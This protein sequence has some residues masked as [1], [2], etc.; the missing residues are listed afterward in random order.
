VPVVT[1]IE[2]LTGPARL[3]STAPLSTQ[4]HLKTHLIVGASKFAASLSTTNRNFLDRVRVKDSAALESGFQQGADS[5]G[6]SKAELK[7]VRSVRSAR[8]AEN[9]GFSDRIYVHDASG[10]QA[11]GSSRLVTYTSARSPK[12]A[13]RGA[14]G[15]GSVI[16]GFTMG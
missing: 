3:A 6:I 1:Q 4:R 15:V 5:L 16:C 7:E 11:N 9:D 10:K 12:L 14:P 13:S 2:T 8:A